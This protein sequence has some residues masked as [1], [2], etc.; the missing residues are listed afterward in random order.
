MKARLAA[1]L[2]IGLFASAC[3]IQLGGADGAPG[4]S[5]AAAPSAETSGGRYSAELIRSAYGVPHV[6]ASD[7]GGVGYGLGYAAAED[8]ACM[9]FDRDLTLRG[10]RAKYL[11]AGENDANIASDL[12]HRALLDDGIVQALL[13][14]PEGDVDTPGGEARAF[15]EGYAAGVNRWLADTGAANIPDP[16]CAGA[17]HIQPLTANSVWSGVL[18]LPFGQLI[19]PVISAAPPEAGGPVVEARLDLT[20][21]APVMGS[22]AYAIGAEASRNRRGVLLGNPHYPWDGMLRFYRSHLI[23]PGEL[24]VVGA[25]LVTTPFVGIG[26]TEHLAWSH[27]VS[28]AR[29]YGFFELTL[30]PE[31]ATRY[32]VDGESRPMRARDITIEVAGEDGATAQ[33]TRTLYETE[34]G[35]LVETD[36][37]AWTA[38][39]AFAVAAPSQG[40]RFIDQYL[41]MYR[42]GNVREL[43]DALS[44][45]QAT[46]FNTIAA[47]SGGEAYLGDMGLTPAV[48]DALIAACAASDLARGFW[49]QARTPVLDASRSECRWYSDRPGATRVSAAGGVFGPADAPSIFRDDFTANSND[50]PW[51]SNPE[52]PLTAYSAIYGDQGT[53]RSLRTRLGVDQIEQRLAGTD[54]LG[55]PGFDLE[56]ITQVMFSNRHHGGELVRDDLVTLCREDGG[57]ELQPACEALASW[58]LKVDTDSRGALL[59]NAFAGAGGLQWAVPYDP[60]QPLTTPHTLDVSNP[61]VLTALRTGAGQL[62]ALSIPLD[63][64]LGEFQTEPRGDAR[65]PIHG[66]PGHLGVFNMIYG[67]QPQPELGIA[68][69]VHGSSWI[70]A[71]EFTEDGPFAQGILSYSQSTNP[72]S[73]HFADQTRA[74]SAKTWIGM[75]Y[76]EAEVRAEAV[77]RIELEE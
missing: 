51:L 77:S 14:G 15:I 25:G 61:A 74:Y 19:E 57:P 75:P 71:V 29:R 76:Y 8:N 62:A 34:F 52:A 4:A 47:D 59:F 35:P 48:D 63:A 42:A 58:D 1:A 12:Y 21:E 22:N 28:T 13:N 36:R 72:N 37:M 5:P 66:G 31:D 32:L 39:R 54:G 17:A 18:I 2:A 69:I 49:I 44:R 43:H 65:I 41:A 73:P 38:E 30:D 26:H 11:G 46:A 56:T 7:Y 9:I 53:Q 27:T 50:S 10:E 45:Y 70:M 55:E 20:D 68:K 24:N 67:T 40:L 16:R 60:A 3:A 64:P 6:I 33:L 23:I